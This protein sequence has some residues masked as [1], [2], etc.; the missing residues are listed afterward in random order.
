LRMPGPCRLLHSL[1]PWRRNMVAVPAAY[2]S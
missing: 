2:V 1:A